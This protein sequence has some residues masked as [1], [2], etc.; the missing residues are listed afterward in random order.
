MKFMTYEINEGSDDAVDQLLNILTEIRENSPGTN[1]GVSI[2]GNM[3]EV[4]NDYGDVEYKI[5]I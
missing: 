3:L 4:F 5:N 1:Y 2:E